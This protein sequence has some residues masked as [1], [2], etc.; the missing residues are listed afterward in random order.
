MPDYR[1]RVNRKLHVVTAECVS[2]QTRT[3]SGGKAF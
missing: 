3:G 1:L 2:V